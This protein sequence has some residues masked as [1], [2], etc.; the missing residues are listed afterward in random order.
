MTKTLYDAKRDKLKRFDAPE[1]YHAWLSTF[2]FRG[3]HWSG[4]SREDNLNKLANGDMSLVQEAEALVNKMIDAQVFT[5]G[6]PMLQHSV[7]GFVPNVPA[8]II[9][10]P[11]DM[12][13]RN[14]EDTQSL[15]S[16]LSIYAEVVV[17]GGVSHEEL[18]QRGIAVLA[19][20]MAMQSVRPIEL[21]TYQGL[22]N[23]HG[24]YGTVTK[25]ETKPL[26]LA[27]AAWMLTSPGYARTLA[28]AGAYHLGPADG[29]WPWNSYPVKS[30]Y[31]PSMREMLEM[32]PEDIFLCGAFLNDKL[33]LS[34]PVE[35]VR[36]MI[37]KHSGVQE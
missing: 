29:S 15:N 25:V 2:Q 12:W 21:Y 4:G 27:R 5:L 30:E 16:P 14:T 37:A 1:E 10:H 7:V 17:S 18:M 35:W 36:Q 19:F 6:V 3:D 26:D 8:A 22:G 28:F 20:V 11:K 9:G 32:Q 23:S 31:E 33:A 13:R 24:A 34:N